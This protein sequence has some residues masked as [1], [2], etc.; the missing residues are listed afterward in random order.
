[1]SVKSLK[2]PSSL[3]ASRPGRSL[4]IWE[5]GYKAHTKTIGSKITQTIFMDVEVLSQFDSLQF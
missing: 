2:S 1:M 5:P 3:R 4:R